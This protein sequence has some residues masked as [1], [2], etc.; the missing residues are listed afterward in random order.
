MTAGEAL[1][2]GGRIG[3]A[4]PDFGYMPGF[5]NHHSAEAEAGALPIGR[6]SPPRPPPG[7]HA[8]RLLHYPPRADATCARTVSTKARAASSS[9]R[10]PVASTTNACE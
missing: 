5:G 10:A 2:K 9:S 7:L 8:G 6:N 1:V 3:D 4:D